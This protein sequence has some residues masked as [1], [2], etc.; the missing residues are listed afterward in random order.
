M[1]RRAPSCAAELAQGLSFARGA[2]RFEKG[3]QATNRANFCYRKR[4]RENERMQRI[5]E[6]RNGGEVELA[7]GEEIEVALSETATTGYRW[8]LDD[9]GAAGLVEVGDSFEPGGPAPGAAGR[10]L[11]RFRGDREGVS[12][13]ALSLR[14]SW[15]RTPVATFA[16][17]VRVKSA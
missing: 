3:L 4:R 6:T 9:R 10:R 2:L 13:V 12:R 15:E 7:V 14:R 11:W 17:T 5:N 1:R 16:L 8:R